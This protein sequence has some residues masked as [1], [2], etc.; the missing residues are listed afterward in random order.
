MGRDYSHSGIVGGQPLYAPQLRTPRASSTGMLTEAQRLK[1]VYD[2]QTFG[3]VSKVAALNKVK[4]DTVRKWVGVF[5]ATGSVAT[6]P[7]SGRKKLLGAAAV[8]KA[9]AML[10]SGKYAGTKDV[11]KELHKAKLSTS[12][13]PVHRTTLARNAKARS[14]ELGSPIHAVTGEPAKELSPQTKQKRL[15]FAKKH[16][17]TNWEH[18]MF[19]DRKRFYFRYPGCCVRRYAWVEKGQKRQA[20]KVSKP[21]AVNVYAGITKFGTTK[22]HFVAGTHGQKTSHKTR[23]G[24]EARSIT[25]SEYREVLEKTLLPEGTKIFK[26]EGIT[27]WIFQQDNDPSHGS[28][29][30]IIKAWSQQQRGVKVSLL[31]A[32]PG[33]SPDLNPIENLWAWA[34]RKVD[35]AGCKDFSSFK[36]CVSKTLHNAPKHLLEAYVD[37]ME[38]RLQACIQNNGD[39]TKY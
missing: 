13:R 25:K 16:K 31:L 21:L 35:E 28:A 14:L 26:N 5:D 18:V 11:A 7:G 4:R 19:S 9:I 39:K 33:N 1:L 17:H 6:C 38:N 12:A 2:W 37:S 27:D 23:S 36:K 15:V 8:D 22:L 34:Q 10:K 29:S 20:K 3:N 30:G 32:W 24:K